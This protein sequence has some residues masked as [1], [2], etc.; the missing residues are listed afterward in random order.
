MKTFFRMPF[1][2]L[3]LVAFSSG[4]SSKTTEPSTVLEPVTLYTNGTIW[5]GV[6][7]AQDASVMVVNDG[8]LTYVGDGANIRVAATETVD[9][10]GRFVMPGFIDSHVHFY[11]GGMGLASVDLRDAATPQEFIQRISTY[12]AT[13][14]KNRWVLIGNWDHENWG[15]KLPTK[16]WIDE[17]T[18]D[19]PVFI[20]RIDGHMALANSVALEL[21]G[22]T[23]ATLTPQGGE[24][25]RDSNN[26]PTGILKDNALALIASAI[27]VPTDEERLEVF[28]LA[29]KHALSLGLTQVHAVSAV[30]SETFLID[31]FKYAR[32]QGV[33]KLR[34]NVYS[35]LQHWTTTRDLVERDGLGDDLLNWGG[36]K[37]MIDGSLGSTTAWFYDS[38]VDASDKSGFALIESDRLN[39]LMDEADVNNLKLAIHAIGDKAIDEVID[40]FEGVADDQIKSRRYRIEHFQHPSRAAIERLAKH[41]IIASMQPYHA[42][43]DGRWAEERVGSERIKTTYAFR[44][45]LDAG[46]LLAFGSDWPVAPLS[47][48][49]G[50]YAAVTRRTTDGANPEGWQPQEKIS[51]EE[52]LTA[53]TATN[54]YAAFEEN[55]AGT[56]EPGKRADFV[57]LSQDPRAA[58]PTAIREIDVLKTVIAGES[59]FEL[60]D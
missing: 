39:A 24:I 5:T 17:F 18:P 6:K 52:A 45:I 14:E 19:N 58:D 23:S 33:M 38:Y 31:A 9:L 35:P 46:G 41:K 25:L 30:P 59:V 3:L 8:V 44:S 20:V 40:G 36:V 43:D 26:A 12:V 21:A 13:L 47:P 51:V 32:D 60:N 50:V 29:Q 7:G 34:V 54:A 56:L 11:D 10:D 2:W 48:L 27:P 16:N 4:C 42:I 57:V 55:R 53:Y 49:D 22:V 37:G 28:E 1:V 15:G